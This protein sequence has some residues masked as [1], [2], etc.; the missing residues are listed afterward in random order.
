MLGA[1]PD[2]AVRVSTRSRGVSWDHSAGS[3][4]V[5]SQ[6]SV[7]GRS[8]C[9]LIDVGSGHSGI[10]SWASAGEL[11]DEDAVFILLETDRVT[12]VG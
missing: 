6:D 9:Y 3:E 1:E 4:V 2:V 5:E 12:A 11:N 8:L 7:V 10:G